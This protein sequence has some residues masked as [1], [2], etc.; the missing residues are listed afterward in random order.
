MSE[1]FAR[2]SK[3]GK[4]R[5]KKARSYDL[6][7]DDDPNATDDQYVSDVTCWPVE[8]GHIFGY[9][10]KQAGIYMQEQ[11]LSWKQLDAY[12]YFQSGYVRTVHM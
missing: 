7:L 8:Y 9:F 6:N 10:M 11:L 1:Y 12:N 5:Y 4:A 3:E 2:L